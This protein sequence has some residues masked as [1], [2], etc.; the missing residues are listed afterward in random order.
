MKKYQL[1]Q[2]IEEFLNDNEDNTI[3]T[4][5]LINKGISHFLK[6][7]EEGTHEGIRKLQKRLTAIII[8]EEDNEKMSEH[9]L[10][11]LKKVYEKI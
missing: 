11:S 7:K 8:I 10:S 9:A 6:D 3:E 5:K 4:A 2:L 1:L